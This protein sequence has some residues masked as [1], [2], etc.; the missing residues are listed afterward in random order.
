M[1][2]FFGNASSFRDVD[3][4]DRREP[5]PIANHAAAPKQIMCSRSFI[6]STRQ[7]E[8]SM[9]LLRSTLQTLTLMASAVWSGKNGVMLGARF[10]I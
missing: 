2:L 1:L 5:I 9:R 7:C 4:G 10:P 6:V 8:T 3:I